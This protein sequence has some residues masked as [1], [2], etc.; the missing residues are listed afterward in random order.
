MKRIVFV[1]IGALVF[2]GCAKKGT[3]VEVQKSIDSFEVVFLFEKDGLQV[4]RFYD[5]H[6]YRYFTIGSGSFQP[7]MQERTTSNGKTTRVTKWVDG[8]ETK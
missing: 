5:A 2:A 6:E 3:Q 1:L 7:Q 8:A 4:Y